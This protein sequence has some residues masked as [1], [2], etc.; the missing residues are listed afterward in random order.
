[1][2]ARRTW[3]GA[4]AFLVLTV[5]VIATSP[6]KAAGP[7]TTERCDIG[8]IMR[9]GTR[10]SANLSLPT[11]PGHYPTLLTTTPYG[12][13]AGPGAEGAPTG[14][15]S[16]PG[17]CPEAGS[18]DTVG[19]AAHG[20]AV[21]SVDWRGTGK[22]AA[23]QWYTR[24]WL[25]D[26]ADIL[27]WVQAQP[28]SND[29]VGVTG[30]SNLGGSTIVLAT[31]D[32]VRMREGKPRAVYAAW[33]DSFFPD[34]YRASVGQG[35]ASITPATLAIV[36]L[37]DGSYAYRQGNVS[38]LQAYQPVVAK[39]A[40]INA[41]TSSYDQYWQAV[42]T[43][44]AAKTLDI[45]LGMTAAISDLWQLGLM[46]FDYALRTTKSTH[47]SFF[48]SPGG[49]CTQGGWE[50]LT[51]GGHKPGTKQALVMAWFDHWLKGAHNGI[52]RLPNWNI[53][54]TGAK[55]W[56]VQSAAMPTPGTSLVDLY[57]DNDGNGSVTDGG[58]LAT[59][60]PARAGRDELVCTCGPSASADPTDT[61]VAPDAT[62]LRY[63]TPVF[64][65]DTTL[66]GNAIA[67]LS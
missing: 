36:G 39:Q 2:T 24:Q 37:I 51:Y 35:G 54:P 57:L 15:P 19:A 43:T 25:T 5:G 4:L 46:P 17:Q 23:G 22:S 32:Q 60:R 40:E 65:R 28:W 59:K 30:C 49:H 44:A 14:P 63:D 18:A 61:F 58:S 6:A 42:D 1:M 26:S 50:S 10:L 31:A 53:Y 64:T 52:D 20:Y 13:D 33:A 11:R 38:G 8:I 3:R 7:A 16:L 67:Q 12:K 62:S 27:D 55:G 66:A 29:R 47:P 34:V 41:G 56:T 45:P 48:L 21:L 9:D